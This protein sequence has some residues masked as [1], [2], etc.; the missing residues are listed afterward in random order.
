MCIRDR[1]TLNLTNM[2]WKKITT[3]G[4]TPEPRFGHTA[5]EVHKNV[6]VFGGMQKSSGAPRLNFNDMH[7]IR[8]KSNGSLEWQQIETKG[9]PPER[10]HGHTCVRQK[11]W[12]IIFGGRGDDN[13]LF[14][15]LFLFN[16]KSSTWF[17]VNVEGD[18][19][20]PRFSHG[21]VNY[22]AS[23]LIYGGSATKITDSKK[24]QLLYVIPF[25]GSHEDPW[26]QS[27]CGAT[28]RTRQ[29]QQL[30]LIHI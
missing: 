24:L 12:L 2:E 25:D 28:N 23:L 13:K 26:N 15:D 10:R 3:L 7:K 21:A 9:T 1:Y 18:I 20:C 6:Y 17:K 4:D 22:G 14:N 5:T 29:E 30:S 8:L 27:T 16:T 11:E 19:P